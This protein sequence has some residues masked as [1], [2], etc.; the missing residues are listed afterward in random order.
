MDVCE[1]RFPS[2]IRHFPSETFGK[3]FFLIHILMNFHEIYRF[4]VS[5]NDTL[6]AKL[7]CVW[8]QFSKRNTPFFSKTLRKMFFFIQILRIFHEILHIF[9]LKTVLAAGQKVRGIFVGYVNI[10]SCNCTYLWLYCLWRSND[11]ISGIFRIEIEKKVSDFFLISRLCEEIS[12]T[13]EMIA[14]LIRFWL[15]MSIWKAHLVNLAQ[16]IQAFYGVV[17][18]CGKRETKKYLE[19]KILKKLKK[20]EKSWFLDDLGS[21]WL[22]GG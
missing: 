10:R 12:R 19:T 2:K 17:S 11:G 20:H 3:T 9:F 7:G 16:E 22:G 1:Y 8:V 5:K 15:R 4:F 18:S 21:G 14:I 6:Q 13:L